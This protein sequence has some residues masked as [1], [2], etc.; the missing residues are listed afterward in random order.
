L[1]EE[2]S[3]TNAHDAQANHSTKTANRVYGRPQELTSEVSVWQ[4]SCS[5]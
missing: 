2:E 4:L 1:D 3:E 5:Q